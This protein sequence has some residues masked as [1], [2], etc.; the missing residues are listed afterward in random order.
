MRNSLKEIGRNSAD[1]YVRNL[2][3]A[4]QAVL[5]GE[6]NN[7]K[8]LRALAYSHRAVAMNAYRATEETISAEQ[9][10]SES[11]RSASEI[12]DIQ[13]AF[14]LENEHVATQQSAIATKAH[15]A[16]SGAA[17]V[18]E[19]IISQLVFTCTNCGFIVEGQKPEACPT[20]SALGSEFEAFG[21][22]FASDAEHLGRQTPDSVVGIL[23]RTVDDIVNATE[24]VDDATMAQKPSPSEWSIKEIIGHIIETDI[25]FLRR[26]DSLLTGASY[27]QPV[28]PWKL[29]EGKDYNARYRD[30]LIQLLTETRRATISRIQDLTPKEWATAAVLLGGKRSVL[31]TG[32]WIA[33]HDLGHLEQIKRLGKM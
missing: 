10:L 20:C 3:A 6:F 16:I 23:K 19:W 21:P 30:D 33:N 28:P 9:A 29:H 31:D 27:E 18:P 14:E 1:L 24:S 26:I 15:K 8:V 2:I 5:R 11:I 4:E 13:D 17:D 7:A 22:F 25:L 12:Q 32:T